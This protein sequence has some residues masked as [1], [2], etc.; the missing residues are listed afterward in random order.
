ME[1][2]NTMMPVAVN[3]QK[4]EVTDIVVPVLCHCYISTLTFDIGRVRDVSP[5]FLLTPGSHLTPLPDRFKEI[6]A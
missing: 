4:L 5:G 3:N 2:S 6:S 1:N